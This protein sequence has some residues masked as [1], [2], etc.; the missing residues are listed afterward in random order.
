MI[1]RLVYVS[2]LSHTMEGGSS[3]TRELLRIMNHARTNNKL[4]DISGALFVSGNYCMQVLEGNTPQVARLM[5]K[6]TQDSRHN[7]VDLIYK[8]AVQ[9]RVFPNWA[10]RLITKGTRVY[11]E[12]MKKLYSIDQEMKISETESASTRKLQWKNFIYSSLAKKQ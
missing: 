4:N 3:Y 8:K 10:M 9:D 7:N 6:I 12:G 5:F 1:T 11:S 2:T